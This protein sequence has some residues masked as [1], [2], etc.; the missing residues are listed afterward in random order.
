LW[1][2]NLEV[3][4]ALEPAGLLAESSAGGEHVH[5]DHTGPTANQLPR[6]RWLSL[7]SDR[8][9]ISLQQGVHNDCVFQYVFKF[10]LEALSV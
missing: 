6:G 5:G 1:E 8:P 9:E 7:T 4:A 10:L 3:Q 2:A